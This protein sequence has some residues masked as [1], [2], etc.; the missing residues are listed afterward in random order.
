MLN[1][2]RLTR[3]STQTRFEPDSVSS[4]CL[5][6][7]LSGR[8][9]TLPECQLLTLSGHGG[10]SESSWSGVGDLVEE[11]WA[12]LRRRKRRKPI[13]WILRTRALGVT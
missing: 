7:A 4:R 6:V 2:P 8:D 13:F 5:L 3:R 10:W 12:H 9:A 11:G 1:Q